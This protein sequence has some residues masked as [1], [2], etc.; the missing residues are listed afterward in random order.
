MRTLQEAIDIYKS[1]VGKTRAQ[2]EDPKTGAP[3]LK[4]KPHNYFDCASGFS[5]ASGIGRDIY[6]CGTWV[7][8]FKN[9]KTWHTT[10]LPKR[11]D[12]VIFS[13]DGK[14]MRDDGGE[15][16]HIGLCAIDA[17]V[18]KDIY[19]LSADSTDARIVDLHH[20]PLKFVSGYATIPWAPAK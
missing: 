9:E 1:Y 20:V 2:L 14:G 12:A 8:H 5:Y 6:S 19:Y 10:G 7:Q 11:G 3:W 13:W 18:G 16:D 4:G 17:E 15:H